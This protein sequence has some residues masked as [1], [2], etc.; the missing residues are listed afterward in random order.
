[1]GSLCKQDL[2][3]R[4]MTSGTRRGGLGRWWIAVLMAIVLGAFAVTSAAWA[5][6]SQSSTRQTVPSRTPTKQPTFT[7]ANTPLPTATPTLATPSA[8]PTDAASPTFTSTPLT[9]D[10]TAGPTMAATAGPT[11]ASASP[12]SHPLP[13][14]SRTPTRAGGATQLPESGADW[15]ATLRGI[16]WLL[17]SLIVVLG[18]AALTFARRS[19][20][21]RRAG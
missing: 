10:P 6:P 21:D 18:L 19:P 14:P 5:A 12:T 4:S 15:G 1:M 20:T 2:W 7:P 3:G 13:S 11:S 9:P 17:L 8:Q 16:G